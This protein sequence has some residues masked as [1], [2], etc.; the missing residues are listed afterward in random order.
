MPRLQE[1]GARQVFLGYLLAMVREILS[2]GAWT[3]QP[4]T[5]PAMQGRAVLGF[6]KN[7]KI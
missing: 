6:R 4:L 7:T 3:I 1:S 5:Q 2:G